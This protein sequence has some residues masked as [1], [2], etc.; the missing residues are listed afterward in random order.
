MKGRSL[1][2]LGLG[3]VPFEQ[4]LTY[5][6]PPVPWPALLRGDR[7]LRLTGGAGPL[8]GMYVEGG[9]RL[10]QVLDD[11]DRRHPVLAVGS[12][13]CPAQ[14]AYKLARRSLG[15]DVPM[16][17]VTVRGLGIGCSAHVGRAGY[18]A[19]AP[20][21]DPDS[22]RTLVLS[23][24]D[25][26]Q[27]AAVDATELPYYRRRWLDEGYLRGDGP[28]AW[29]YTGERGVLAGPDGRPLAAGEQEALL[30]GLLAGSAALRALLGPDARAW[31]R[32][33]RADEAVRARAARL[34]AEEG[35]VLHPTWPEP[36]SRGYPPNPY[37]GVSTAPTS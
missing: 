8:G 6:G 25:D 16:L 4:P 17:P 3:V 22:T 30:A 10:D 34:F 31:V 19:A 32:A 5:P 7:L 37:G 33:A 23:W 2:E 9:G 15:S 24:L 20:Y 14:V 29:V 1:V 28:G 36:S 12:N 26:A 18:V 27:L 35:L 13:A 21:P 11:L